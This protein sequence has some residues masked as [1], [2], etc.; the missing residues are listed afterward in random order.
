MMT[1]STPRIIVWRFV[2]A[3]PGHRRQSAGLLQALSAH[4]TLDVHTVEVSSFRASFSDYLFKRLPDTDQLSPPQLIVGAGRACQWPMICARRARAAFCVYLMKPLWPRLAFDLCFIPRH[5]GVKPGSRVV[6]TDGVLNDIEIR[7]ESRDG[8]L[9]LV[10][11]PSTHYGFDDAALMRQIDAI[12]QSEPATTWTLSNSRRTPTTFQQS[13]EA[14]A[15]SKIELVDVA[16]TDEAWI[17]QALASARRVWVSADS[18]SMMFEALSAGCAVGILEMPTKRSSRITGIV[19]DLST[20]GLVTRFRDWQ[21]DPL[22]S[23]ASSL[24]EAARAAAIVHEA[25]VSRGIAA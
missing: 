20:R 4:A 24:N 19:D 15:P 18:V 9:I 8:N 14:L 21:G 5:D 13:L 12:V 10:G 3:K 16:N 7:D 2:D 23:P 25:L 11:G 6:V 17:K 1:T 22:K